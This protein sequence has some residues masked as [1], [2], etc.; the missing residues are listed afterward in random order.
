MIRIPGICNF[1]PET[2]V[3]C[4]YRLMGLSG[5][6]MKPVDICGAWG[7]SA[8]HDVVDRRSHLELDWQEVR[9]LHAEGVIR[10]LNELTRLGFTAQNKGGE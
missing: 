5:I 2:T 4:H 8:C 7:C 1:D 9:F 10:T 6:G 3:L